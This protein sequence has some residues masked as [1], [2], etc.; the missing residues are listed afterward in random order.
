MFELNSWQ[1]HSH[2]FT[3]FQ[4]P[5]GWPLG[6]VGFKSQ[7]RPE[8]VPFR[9]LF[10]AHPQL[11]QCQAMMILKGFYLTA[12]FYPF[13]DLILGLPGHLTS[14]VMVGPR[15]MRG[16]EIREQ[17]EVER[18]HWTQGRRKEP[19]IKT[20]LVNKSMLHFVHMLKVLL[21]HELKLD[22]ESYKPKHTFLQ[23]VMMNLAPLIACQL[24]WG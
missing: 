24:C 21:K 9:K 8:F 18:G 13:G 7:S 6:K 2:V 19:T 11:E 12:C 5:G 17:K 15:W 22:I 14:S 4:F 20:L 3:P 1:I 23:T 16:G 10:L